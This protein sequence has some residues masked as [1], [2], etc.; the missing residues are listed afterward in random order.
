MARRR[1]NISFD[2]VNGKT[3]VFSGGINEGIANLELRPGDLFKCVNYE[4]IDG[5]YH[6]YSSVE[7]FERI[8]GQTSPSD[9][10]VTLMFDSGVANTETNFL[11]ESEDEEDTLDHSSNEVP[12]DLS[13]AVYDNSRKKFGEGS[14]RNFNGSP[15]MTIDDTTFDLNDTEWTIDGH[16]QV[17]SPL[18]EAVLVQKQGVFALKIDSN[19]LSMTVQTTGG[20]VV[21]PCSDPVVANRWQE[22]RVTKRDGMIWIGANGSAEGTVVS[23]YTF[24][25]NS[26]QITVGE[27]LTGQKMYIDSVRLS[28]K[29]WS[30]GDYSFS[31]FK[32]YSD[33]SYYVENADDIQREAY[34]DFIQPVPGE[35]PIRDVHVYQGKAFALRD[36]VGGANGKLHTEGGGGWNSFT[37]SYYTLDYNTG[38]IP[39]STVEPQA[40]KTFTTPG[41]AAG[42]MKAHTLWE[43]D[44]TSN[45]GEGYLILDVQ[46]GVPVQGEILTTQDGYTATITSVPEVP[47][48]GAGENADFV[49]GRFAY[50]PQTAPNTKVMY[51]ISGGGI[52]S[53]DGNS[54]TPIR[55][56]VDATGDPKHIAIFSDR[57]WI[58]YEN[59]HVFYSAA[60]TPDNFSGFFGAGEIFFGDNVND[61]IV[62]PGPAFA[63]IME[64]S[65]KLVKQL[66]TDGSSYTFATE[67]FLK[68]SGGFRH[69]AAALHGDIYFCDDRGPTN[70]SVTD[71]FGDFTTGNLKKKAHVTYQQYK[72]NILGAYVQRAKS[73]YRV[74][75]SDSTNGQTRA[76]FTTLSEKKVKGTTLALYPVEFSCFHEG[77]TEG[78]DIKIVAGGANG[79]VYEMD[80]GTSFDGETINTSFESAY[81]HYG[82]PRLWKRFHRV[83]F[84][85]TSTNR[86]Q[87]FIKPKYNYSSGELANAQTQEFRTVG[88]AAQW[89]FAKWGSF[90]WGGPVVNNPMVY[91][92]GYGNNFSMGIGTT[93]KY[94]RHTIHN[95]I[96]DY[97]NGSRL[98]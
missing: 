57:L 85:I 82:T 86:T 15:I 96:V 32:P 48:V 59:G 10:E 39:D 53:C 84:E 72:D 58:A 92:R 35:G 88:Q 21:I 4:E 20:A 12:V 44:P 63:V 64:N 18:Q 52:F 9:I 80:K 51:F 43:G 23:S 37:E 55:G 16:F 31:D 60:G 75:F 61:M 6:G 70:L 40:G 95:M 2:R 90:V 87:F 79:Y 7:G 83:L 1:S 98:M 45:A 46:V 89:G 73:Q 34:R 50:Y 67:D 71:A 65:F 33:G 42:T 24:I 91:L 78:Q 3:V 56:P 22:I 94:T 8:D 36:I 93:S 25:T 74:F 19:V 27:S 14:W 47:V 97:S 26:N 30:V 77:E 41:G 29:A 54:V 66:T 11:Y 76:I 69:T 68:E 38:S 13:Q 81:Y 5:A 17:S 49:T 62:T 28:S